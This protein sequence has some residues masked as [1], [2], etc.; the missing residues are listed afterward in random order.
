MCA[1]LPTLRWIAHLQERVYRLALHYAKGEIT[2]NQHIIIESILGTAST[3]RG[4]VVDRAQ[5]GPYEAIVPEVSGTA[6]IT[7]Q[8]EF[9]VDPRDGLRQ[10]FLLS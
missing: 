6:F 2:D 4:Q 9:I 1:S 7:G 10:G 8:H 3:F 5:V